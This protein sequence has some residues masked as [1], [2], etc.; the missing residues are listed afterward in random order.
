MGRQLETRISRINT[1][2]QS[3]FIPGR[4]IRE[5]RGQESTL[6]VVGSV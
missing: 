4:E 3:G 2:L 5:V 6:E 1:N